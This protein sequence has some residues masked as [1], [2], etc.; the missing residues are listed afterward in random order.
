[1][2]Y[3]KIR[4]AALGQGWRIEGTKAGEMFYSPDGKTKALWHFTPSDPRAMKNF[5]S[6]LKSGGLEWPA[7]KKRR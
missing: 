6:V 4:K 1:M 3:R 2:D 5:L 7:S